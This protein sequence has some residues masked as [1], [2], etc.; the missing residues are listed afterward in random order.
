MDGPELA[1]GCDS[2][3]ADGSD[4]DSDCSSLFQENASEDGLAIFGMPVDAAATMPAS[5]SE[6]ASLLEQ[7]PSQLVLVGMQIGDQGISQLTEALRTSRDKA[8]GVKVLDLESNCIGPAGALELA[9]VCTDGCLS[10]LT[11]LSLSD[12]SIGP[13]GLT[14]LSTMLL[15]GHL[16]QLAVLNINANPVGN[17]GLAVLGSAIAIGAL[18]KLQKLFLNRC[19]FTDDGLVVFS[20]AVGGAPTQLP[21]LYELWLSN[22]SI[23]DRGACALFDALSCGAMAGLGD[24]RLQFNHIGDAGFCALATAAHRGALANL[25][26]LGLNDNAVTDVGLLALQEAI[27]KEG[28]LPKLEFVT[29]SSGGDE[30][31]EMAQQA[32]QDAFT[33]RR[34]AS[35]KLVHK[36]L[37][38]VQQPSC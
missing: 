11:L 23:G 20:R 22:N 21:Q 33:K 15:S 17:D 30:S 10:Q 31:N 8:S 6:L 3:V 19:G 32:F 38:R 27:V 24:L 14:A 25:W 35:A 29:A 12:N 34:A 28:S 26:Y 18:F 37:V 5:P 36:A 13:V 1:G 9:D 7:L 2:A 4:S 16:P